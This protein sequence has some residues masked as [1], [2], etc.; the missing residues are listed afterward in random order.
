MYYIS[1]GIQINKNNDQSE[2]G[3]KLILTLTY[4]IDFE[5][6]NI[7]YINKVAKTYGRIFRDMYLQI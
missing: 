4:D 2:V 1:Y 3:M 6:L 7:D 5:D